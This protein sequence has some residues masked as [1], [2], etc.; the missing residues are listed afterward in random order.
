[1]GG[2]R[3]LVG[4]YDGASTAAVMVDGLTDLPFGPLFRG[5]DAAEQ[6]DAFVSWING[7]PRKFTDDSLLFLYREWS[8]T[9]ISDDDTLLD[10]LEC[11]ACGHVHLA[12]DDYEDGAPAECSQ[13]T[14][15]LDGSGPPRSCTCTAQDWRPG[16]RAAEISHNERSTR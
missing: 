14:I 15:P 13:W 10:P 5:P 6:V 16:N 1:M 4:K 9:Y 8:E 11:G 2:V 12:V 7:D 3:V